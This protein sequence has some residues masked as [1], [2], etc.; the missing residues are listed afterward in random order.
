MTT[1]Y[2]ATIAKYVLVEAANDEEAR[3]RG[4][5]ALRALDPPRTVPIRIDIIRPATADEI[6]LQ[7]W[8]REAFDGF[9]AP[10]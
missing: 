5:E 10:R 4:Q 7:R 3:L 9:D 8:H 6:E 2:V 1:Y